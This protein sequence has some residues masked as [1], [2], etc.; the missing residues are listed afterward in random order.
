MELKLE[1]RGVVEKTKQK[2][3]TLKLLGNLLR[4]EGGSLF[5]KYLSLRYYL[6]VI[7]NSINNYLL[8]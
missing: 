7:R 8:K 1:L 6:G 5:E 4:E 2:G 3:D